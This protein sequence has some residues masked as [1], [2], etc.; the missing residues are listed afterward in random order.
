MLERMAVVGKIVQR[1]RTGRQNRGLDEHAIF[2][3]AAGVSRV[4][5]RHLPGGHRGA[6]ALEPTSIHQRLIYS[7][8]GR[9]DQNLRARV[10]R[11]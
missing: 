4:I 11:E 6:L 1:V 2:E 7:L 5:E 10:E 9:D 3:R 8:A